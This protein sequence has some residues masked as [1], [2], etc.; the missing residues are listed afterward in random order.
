M[1]TIQIAGQDIKWYE[2]NFSTI[3]LPN[4]TLLENNKSYYASQTI[5]CESNR[6]AILIRIYDT[7]PPTGNTNQQFCIDA[8]TQISNLNILGSN[9][10]WYDSLTNGTALAETTALSNGVTYY[11]TQTLNDCES[12]RIAITVRIQDTQIPFGN[13]N[14][15]FC[16]QENAKISNIAIEGQN[17]KWYASLSSLTTLSESILLENGMTYYASQ[18]ISTCE[19][20][21]TAIT[22]NILE[23]TDAGCIDLVDE[24]PYPKFFTPNGDG[25]NDTWTINFAYLKSN[26]VIKIFDRYGKL[27][28]VLNQ[29][30][31]WD[32]TFNS[33]QLIATDYWFVVTR[34]DGK[35][36]KGHFSLK[37]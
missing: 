28:T 26:T 12:E 31:S 35:E 15:T 37:R 21:R 6:I 11:A 14:Q 1:S 4:S 3:S 20:Y 7:P 24:L 25:F 30:E 23:A 36:Y 33:Q 9:I 27:I 29:N 32:G 18:T 16:I 13:P 5:G 19:S 8:N 2:T 17:I 22:A 10:K 34:A